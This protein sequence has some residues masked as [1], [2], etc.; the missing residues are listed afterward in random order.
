[1]PPRSAG[2]VATSSVRPC[3]WY[4]ILLAVCIIGLGLVV[5]SRHELAGA[6]GEHLDH[7]HDDDAADHGTADGE[8]PLAGGAVGR[9]LRQGREPA[10][11][12]RPDL[13]HHHD[14]QR[15]RRHPAGPCRHRTPRSSRASKATLGKF[16][17]SEKRR[18]CRHSLKLP[19]SIGKLAGT[20]ANGRKC[21]SKPGSRP[22][23]DLDRAPGWTNPFSAYRD[24]ARPLRQRRDVHAGLRAE[25]AAVP[26]PAAASL[27]EKFYKVRQPR[28]PAPRRPPSPEAAPRR[29][30]SPEAAPRRPRRAGQQHHDD[31]VGGHRTTTTKPASTTTTTG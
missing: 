6:D 22:A 2:A 14:G 31:H 3:G 7:D 21:G 24:A 1:M 29:P 15:R 12:R 4:A 8:R 18:P 16:L 23:A 13:G 27:V 17:D 30:P 19:S 25:G 28:S 5:F 10:A 9:R 20:Y 26:K 11:K